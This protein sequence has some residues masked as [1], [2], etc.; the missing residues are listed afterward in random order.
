M[1]DHDLKLSELP[2][3][4]RNE[5]DPFERRPLL[6]GGSEQWRCRLLSVVARHCECVASW[7]PGAGRGSLYGRSSSVEVAEYLYVVL[8]RDLTRARAFRM[9]E[10]RELTAE[11]RS[12]GLNDFCQSAVLAIEVRCAELRAEEPAD[13]TALVRTRAKGLWNWMQENGQDL[14]KEPPFGYS[15]DETGWKVGHGFKL[16]EAIRA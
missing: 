15:F 10:L 9:M 6:L 8:S 3:A 13:C 16:V 4:Q 1:H 7:R 14:R 12:A 2:P 5:A 11:Q